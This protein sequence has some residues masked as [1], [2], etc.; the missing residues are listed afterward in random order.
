MGKNSQM[1]AM[2]WRTEGMAYALEVVKKD[3]IDGLEKLVKQ[4]RGLGFTLKW[5][6]VSELAAQLEN[7]KT[8]YYIAIVST[9]VVLLHDDHGFGKK[10]SFR[11]CNRFLDIVNSTLRPELGVS[12]MDY[13]EEAKRING[14][15]VGVPARWRYE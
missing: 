3:G 2:K 1:E 12:L 7:A 4:R 11:L 14:M 9:F 13:I 10:R 15:E 6:P 5:V 8:W